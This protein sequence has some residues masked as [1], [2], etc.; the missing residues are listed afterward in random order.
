MQQVCPFQPFSMVPV[1]ANGRVFHATSLVC[2]TLRFA[3]LLDPYYNRIFVQGV[4]L[5]DFQIS[6]LFLLF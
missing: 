5:N 4:Q 1:S 3:C 2:P 6:L